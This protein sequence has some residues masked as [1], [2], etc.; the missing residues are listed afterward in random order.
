MEHTTPVWVK[1]LVRVLAWV[2]VV[3]ACNA[4]LGHALHVVWLYQWSIGPPG[5][6]VNTATCFLV[7]AMALLLLSRTNGAA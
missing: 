1:P 3:I 6:A 5:M 7:T 2:I 4:L